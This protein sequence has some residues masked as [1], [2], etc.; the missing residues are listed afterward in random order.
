MDWIKIEKRLETLPHKNGIYLIKDSQDNS[1]EAYFYKDAG[2]WQS[3]YGIKTSRWHSRKSGEHI[4]NI[5]HWRERV[6]DQNKENS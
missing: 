6:L 4:Y 2:N 5:T 1:Q 3:D